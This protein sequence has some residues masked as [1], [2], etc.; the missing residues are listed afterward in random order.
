MKPAMHPFISHVFM[1]TSSKYD[2]G[3]VIYRRVGLLRNVYDGTFKPI[4]RLME[5]LPGLPDARRPIQH[6]QFTAKYIHSNYGAIDCSGSC[7]FNCSFCTISNVQGRNSRCRSPE[8]IAE[9]I[10]QA[11]RNSGVGFSVFADGDFARNPARQENFDRL[12]ALREHEA[13]TIE[14]IIQ[15]DIPLIWEHS[16]T[17]AFNSVAGSSTSGT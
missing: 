12:I 10:R 17:I 6:Q 7:T 11:H 5:D 8:C 4:H 2:E 9:P 15:T 13:D 1:A 14:P 16:Q 3:F